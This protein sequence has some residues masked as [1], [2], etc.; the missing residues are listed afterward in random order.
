MLIDCLMN[1]VYMWSIERVCKFVFSR[2]NSMSKTIQTSSMT[3]AS[4]ESDTAHEYE[5][6]VYS[7]EIDD[8]ENQEDSENDRDDKHSIYSIN[9]VDQSSFR[10]MRIVDVCR[11]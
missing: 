9:Q 6:D 10:S 2:L 4:S 1:S 7:D 5:D 8:T 3:T 11:L